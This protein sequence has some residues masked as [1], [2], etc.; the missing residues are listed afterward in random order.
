MQLLL[1]PWERGRLPMFRPTLIALPLLALAAVADAADPAALH[2][3]RAIPEAAQRLAC[4]DTLPLPAGASDPAARADRPDAAAPGK[5]SAGALP[6]PAAPPSRAQPAL[7]AGSFG[8]RHEAEALDAITSHIA[9]LFEGWE[10][11]SRIR[12]A[13]GQLWQVV[14][15]SRGSY[16]LREPKVTVR[17]AAMGTFVL[18]IEGAKR[19]PRVRRL[20]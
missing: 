9:G 8:L 7:A 5:A 18:D 19:Q 6:T 13:N 12:L 14:D 11:G 1:V 15:D 2:R 3:C 20:E 16:Y 17:R 10:A 4:Y